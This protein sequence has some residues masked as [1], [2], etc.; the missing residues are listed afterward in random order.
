ME[1]E[2]LIANQGFEQPQELPREA[3]V[4]GMI[5]DAFL[6]EPA[7]RHRERSDLRV[8]RQF[9]QRLLKI[10]QLLRGKNGDIDRNEPT[11]LT[12]NVS[13][14]VRNHTY[15]RDTFIK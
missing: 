14:A 5:R 1:R 2:V 11:D 3:R 8:P 10:R 4:V 6:D 15:F 12:E 13:A 7:K 9:L